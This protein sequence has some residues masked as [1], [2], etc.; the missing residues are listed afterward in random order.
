L[1]IR[2]NAYAGAGEDDR[3]QTT[4]DGEP[5]SPDPPYGAMIV[6]T[7]LAPEGL[8]YLILH[9]AHDGPGYDGDWAWTPPSGSRKPGEPIEACAARELLEET[10]LLATP[11][12][13][14]IEDVDWTV[15]LLGVPPGT[16]II[17]DGVE[18]DRFEWVDFAEAHR[19]CRP[20]VVQANLS[21]AHEAIQL[22]Q[23]TPVSPE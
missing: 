7:A 21:L 4:Y 19:R 23:E 17:S 16:E 14:L 2:E 9:R 3:V 13:L 11:T 6:V 5:I 1:K 20:H 10:G 15:F 22:T 18:H 8:R 12:P